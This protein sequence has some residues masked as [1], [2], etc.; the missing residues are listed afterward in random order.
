MKEI[1]ET[2][3]MRAQVT[4][5][6]DRNFNRL[7]QMKSVLAQSG[8]SE[9]TKR[10]YLD[11]IE[12][13]LA[14][15][16]EV[17]T[18]IS[19][20]EVKPFED[21]KNVKAQ[22]SR[23]IAI[24]HDINSIEAHLG[25]VARPRQTTPQRSAS[26]LSSTNAASSIPARSATPVYS[27]V[28]YNLPDAPTGPLIRKTPVA[29]TIVPDEILNEVVAINSQLRQTKESISSLFHLLP[30]RTTEEKGKR[31]GTCNEL[32]NKRNSLQAELDMIGKSLNSRTTPLSPQENVRMT[33]NLV[34]LKEKI[35]VFNDQILRQIVAQAPKAPTG[36]GQPKTSQDEPPRNNR[37][38]R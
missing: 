18:N 25:N 15:L 32:N 21:H 16:E 30:T 17:K 33:R 12:R 10:S 24:N 6:I 36:T 14:Q 3:E 20:S 22:K 7:L 37:F 8:L 31:L 19:K 9:P 11:L 34:K 23:Y 1:A 29:P 35:T 38:G 27:S 26:T 4:N 5:D 28:T 2:R 13:K